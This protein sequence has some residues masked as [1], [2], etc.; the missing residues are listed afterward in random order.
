MLAENLD[1]DRL[2][3]IREKLKM[4]DVFC[5]CRPD[6]QC[7]GDV[8]MSLANSDDPVEVVKEKLKSPLEYQRR[9]WVAEKIPESKEYRPVVYRVQLNDHRAR[10]RFLQWLQK[11]DE[12]TPGR[13]VNLGCEG[14]DL[15]ITPAHLDHFLMLGQKI[16]TARK[17]ANPILP[18]IP[19]PKDK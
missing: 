6:Q 17:S 19:V 4:R 5:W 3:L 2:A 13:L 14:E 11:W 18:R 10:V 8:L 1:A 12:L 15:N 16:L 7:H 9:Q